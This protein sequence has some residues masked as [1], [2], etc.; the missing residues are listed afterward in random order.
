MTIYSVTENL[1]DYSGYSVHYWICVGGLYYGKLH[2]LSDKT[3]S[4]VH[5]YKT[6][7]TISGLTAIPYE[8]GKIEQ[9]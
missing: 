7:G 2:D 8:A 1:A 3:I 4:K 5:G 6:N 9:V